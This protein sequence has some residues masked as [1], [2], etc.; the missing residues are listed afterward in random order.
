M[1]ALARA[2]T[3]ARAGEALHLAQPSVSR[4]LLSLEERL[5]VPLFERTPRGLVP[6]PAG[7]RLTARAGALL[8]DLADLEREVRRPPAS[9]LKIRLVCA[10]YT[11]YH[12]LPSTLVALREEHPDLEMS[13]RIEHTHDPLQALA[14]G[15]V[16]AALLSS[17]HKPGRK[18]RSGP[19]FADEL[20]FLVAESHPLARVDALTPQHILEHTLLTAAP[21]PDEARWFMTSLFGRARPR[22]KTTIVPLTEALVDLTRVGVGIGVLTE[23]IA[24]P[25]LRRGGLVAKRLVSGPLE[26]A[27]TL[28]WLPSLGETGPR[29]LRALRT[30]SP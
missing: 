11:A 21:T 8:S 30:S 7:E 18:L 6:T 12:W 13:L 22:L 28:A 2:G 26:R 29:L 14:D 1:L 25:Y 4:S 10:C 16:D 15:E 9:P 27:W 20:I 23:W 24:E 5:G 19:L 3:T 17:A